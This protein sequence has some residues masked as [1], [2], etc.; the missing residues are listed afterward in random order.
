MK[1][2]ILSIITF[3]NITI[4]ATALP[5]FNSYIPDTSGEYVYY[6]DKSFKRE[7]YI[8]I[9]CYDNS[10]YEIKYFSPK[11]EAN[12][13]PEKELALLISI[14]PDSDFFD[15]TGE[16]IISTIDYNSDDVD[17]LN[18]L[19]DFLYEFNSKR[20]AKDT[21]T[22]REESLTSNFDLF[23]GKVTFIYDC[24]I[25]LF[26]LRSII[27]EAGEK[28]LDCCTIGQIS[29]ST[30]TS[31]EDFRGFT[32]LPVTAA[33][34]TKAKNA[35]AKSKKYTFDNQA[36]VLDA[37]WEQQME[38]IWTLNDESM[39][40][41][42]EIPFPSEDKVF[43]DFF[44]LRKLTES[45]QGRYTDFSTCEMIQNKNGQYKIIS[46]SHE[47]ADKD[48]IR[49]V[50]LLTP[51]NDKYAYFSISTYSIPYQANTVYFDKIVSKYK[52]K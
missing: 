3:I 19:H 48:T 12:S 47:S 7:S 25:P 30:D 29:S 2:I 34:K 8:G 1:K 23:G 32:S 4:A 11:N 15:M 51:Q 13:E 16:K 36:I 40:T 14:N 46:I 37:K 33:A 28:I 49:S 21:V 20:I 18:Y 45:T 39:V 52:L 10:T 35:R 27:D 9:L 41:M 50:K 43:N 22:C 24:L 44:I 38:N 5:G 26:N 31:F 42:S 6:R 17:I